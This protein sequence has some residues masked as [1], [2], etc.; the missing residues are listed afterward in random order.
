[1]KEAQH[2]VKSA[3]IYFVWDTSDSLQM[4]LWDSR[5]IKGT[6][7]RSDA[8]KL[9]KWL[10]GGPG[11]S[12]TICVKEKF[13]YAYDPSLL[14]TNEMMKVQQTIKQRSSPCDPW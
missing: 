13:A 3:P 5:Q 4:A 11:S 2:N 8:G 9:T 6:S 10:E 14:E 7:P 1:M 12:G